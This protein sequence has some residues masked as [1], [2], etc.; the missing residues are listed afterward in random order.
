MRLAEVAGN[1]VP[2]ALLRPGQAKRQRGQQGRG[3]CRR[4]RQWRR[5][6]RAARGVGAAQ[7]EL[8]RQPL[9]E[10]HPAPR[11]MVA[12][13]QH[14]LRHFRRRR[15]QAMN[16]SGKLGQTQTFAQGR[17][18]RVGQVGRLQR[19]A[20]QAAQ[21]GLAESGRRWIDRSQPFR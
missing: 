6:A 17:R 11:R 5:T 15:V 14:G 3:E 10:L 12:G 20:D 2:G 21:G 4:R 19:A 13:F 9:V 7:A 1:L 16:G 18:Q 8:L